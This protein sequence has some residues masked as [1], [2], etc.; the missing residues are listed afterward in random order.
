[1]KIKPIVIL[2]RDKHGVYARW[3]NCP[4]PRT[5]NGLGPLRPDKGVTLTPS[6]TAAPR[7]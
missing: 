7:A 1:M 6:S 5:L 2:I 4:L 3:V